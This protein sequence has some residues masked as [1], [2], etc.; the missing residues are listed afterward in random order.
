MEIFAHRGASAAFPENTLLAFEQAIVQGADGIELDVQYH[1]D[2]ELIVL[3][4]SHL[5]ITTNGQGAYDELGLTEL[6]RLDAGNQQKIP[7]LA[8]AL[9][10]INGRCAVNIELKDAGVAP[11]RLAA[12]TGLLKQQ[13]EQAIVKENYTWS[14]FIISSFNH[15]LLAAVKQKYP[16]IKTAALI[17][18]CP[19]T[20]SEFTRAL[21]V[22][23]LNVSID[24]LNAALVNDAHDRGLTVGVYT[25]DRQQDI[26]RC[27]ALGVDV[28][29]SNA[30]DK[31]RD[32]L[33]T[34]ESSNI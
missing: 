13:L 20:Y 5:D 29:F 21:D 2:G 10:Q 24:C 16:K 18:S 19:L 34:I 25:V 31:S 6:A 11:G 7:T 27:Y 1:P 23:Q 33:K 8:Q 14:H 30:P 12:I 4:D 9:A 15:H 17:A 3:H 22:C 32:Y 28:I 26:R